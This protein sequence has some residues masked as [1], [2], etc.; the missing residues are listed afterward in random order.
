MK[1]LKT[2]INEARVQYY[3]NTITELCYLLENAPNGGY[4]LNSSDVTY[5]VKDFLAALREDNRIANEASMNGE[6]DPADV[7]SKLKTKIG[8]AISEALIKSCSNDYS[9]Y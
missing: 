9:D 7:I 5:A 2:T 4:T 6:I 3:E 8:K 1:T